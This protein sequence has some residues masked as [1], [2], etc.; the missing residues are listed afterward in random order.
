[1]YLEY[2][3]RSEVVEVG[4]SSPHLRARPSGG[5]RDTN[6]TSCLLPLLLITPVLETGV[7][8]L[9]LQLLPQPRY[10]TPQVLQV[11]ENYFTCHI[12][13]AIDWNPLTSTPF[14]L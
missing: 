3:S 11:Y 10:T 13:V 8:D 2:G 4:S 1:V 9:I 6:P 7:I 5:R 14:H 12:L